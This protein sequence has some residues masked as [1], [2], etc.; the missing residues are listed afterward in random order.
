M[1]KIRLT[2]KFQVKF[3]M[4]TIIFI[5]FFVVTAFIIDDIFINW[6]SI[7]ISLY[8]LYLLISY[9]ISKNDLYIEIN[10]LDL[11]INLVTTGLISIP[12]NEI[13][14]IERKSQNKTKIIEFIMKNPEQFIKNN[15]NWIN[16]ILV[17]INKFFGFPVLLIW[18]TFEKPIDLIYD[19]LIGHIILKE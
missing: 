11:K 12:W 6:I 19:E 18:D 5:M 9:I 16:R 7:L 4:I 8:Y 15:F 2:K 10:D 17:K 14:K 13:K 1:E 3:V